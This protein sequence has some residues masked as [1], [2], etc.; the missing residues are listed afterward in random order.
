MN[1]IVIS[2][3]NLNDAE[4][5]YEISRLSFHSPWTLDSIKKELMINGSARYATARINKRCIGYG[6]VWIILDE[7]HVINIAVHPEY[8]GIGTGEKI[9][10]AL[11]EMCKLENVREM[12]LEVRKSN[13]AALSLYRKFGFIEEGI[14]RK[15]YVDNQEDAIIMWKHTL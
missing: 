11:I 13:I 15:Y 1:N 5:I 6:G 8:R 4:D 12:T 14:R 7:A 3:S 2:A 9:L 10:Q